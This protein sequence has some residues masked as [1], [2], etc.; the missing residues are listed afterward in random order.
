MQPPPNPSGAVTSS[1]SASS[2]SDRPVRLL[3]DLVP[4]PIANCDRQ[5]RFKFVNKSYAERWQR[6]AAD[7]VG[8]HLR[9][10]LWEPAYQSILPHVEQVLSGRAVDFTAEITFPGL[11]TRWLESRYVPDL[12]ERGEV[13]GFLATIF[14]TTERHSAEEA[15]RSRERE[16]SLIYRNVSDVIFLIAVEGPDA[17]R[18]IS[19]NYAFLA[20][21]GLSEADVVG[22]PVSTVIPEPSYALVLSRY[23]RAIRERT[24]VTWEETT[25]YPS[26]TKSGVV[27]V[28]PLFDSQG[29]CK[30]LVGTVHDVTEIKR[31]ESALLEADRRKDE[32]LAM[33][34]HELRNPLGP[35]RNGVQI[36]RQL[37]DDAQTQAR[38][39]AMIERQSAHMSR[40][41]D[42]LLDVS[43]ITRGK[44]LLRHEELELCALVSATAHDYEPQFQQK[45]V[46]LRV[47]VPKTPSYVRGDKTRIAQSVGNLLHNAQ[48]FTSGGGLTTVSVGEEG[49]WATITVVD[50]G[51][52]MEASTLSRLF[53]PFAQADQSLERSAGGLGLGLALVQGLV[54]LHGGTVSAT[55]A[56]V[57]CGSTVQV[58]LP[59]IKTQ[60][61]AESA[62]D[63]STA[64]SSQR[65]LIIEDNADAA[66]SLLLLL[67]LAGHTALSA[68]NGPA[69]LKL[70]ETETPDIIICDI[71][72][73]GGMSGYDIARAVRGQP[74]FARTFMV[75]LTG[76]GQEDDRQA[77]IAA[78]FNLH[79]TKPMDPEKLNAL[80]RQN[81]GR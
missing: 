66:Q 59:L 38:I 16:L 29:R 62:A 53:V 44:I 31:A 11:G 67:S 15:L 79:V 50:T 69:A 5:H 24:T 51:I 77:A 8:R 71:G 27:A 28:T 72:L 21:T 45:N 52:G 40:L 12:D 76:Y 65:A 14:D 6:P 43:R 25:P 4:V 61:L 2:D 48:K 10:V 32:F 41:V 17:F 20:A 49:R 64:V 60:R 73:P 78:G 58:R 26:G 56:G 35:I 57:G 54:Q 22:K 34:A 36:L 63:K 81:G 23:Q 7:I 55:S 74:R 1:S 30:N 42:D 68:E 47:S 39:V 70:L 9:E 3:I 75:A 18:F 46:A 19:V 33:L 80:L 13:Q 37:G